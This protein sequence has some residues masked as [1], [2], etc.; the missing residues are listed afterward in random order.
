[1]FKGT[2][3]VIKEQ[4]CLKTTL[5]C[6]NAQRAQRLP[7]SKSNESLMTTKEQIRA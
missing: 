2:I 3:V 5:E 1:M 6:K 4:K 7:K